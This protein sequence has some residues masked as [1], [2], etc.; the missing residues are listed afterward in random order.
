MVDAVDIK[1]TGT[2]DLNSATMIPD[3]RVRDER[4]YTDVMQGLPMPAVVLNSGGLIVSANGAFADLVQVD[5]A[6]IV[7]EPFL[8]WIG[9]SSEREAFGREFMTMKRRPVGH[10]FVR[11]LSLVAALGQ[12]Y[13]LTIAD[14]KSGKKTTAKPK[15]NLFAAKKAEAA[16]AIEA[17]ATL[18]VAPF[19]QKAATKEVR[20][21]VSRA[22]VALV[23]GM[24][25]PELER[26]AEFLLGQLVREGVDQFILKGHAGFQ[27][28]HAGDQF[29]C[30]VLWGICHSV[31]RFGQVCPE[32]AIMPALFAGVS[33]FGTCPSD[34]GQINHCDQ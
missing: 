3:Q 34:K 28:V 8:T 10:S 33:G 20:T 31:Q 11:E 29:I 1:R 2:F 5:R 26:H 21:G 32:S 4:D 25:R 23:R 24:K 18:L 22:F 15:G 12:P 7:G 17:V 30:R 6:G 14:P 27:F 19:V 13:V 9:R 16:S